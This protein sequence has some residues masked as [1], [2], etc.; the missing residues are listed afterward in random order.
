[1]SYRTAEDVIA[2]AESKGLRYA[3]FVTALQLEM[4]AVLSHI[5]RIGSVVG[6]DGSI[7]ECGIFQDQGNGWIIVVA[8]TGAGNHPAQSVVTYGHRA[9]P[10]FE[11]QILVGVAGSRKTEAPIGSVVASQHVYMPYGG[12][13]GKQGFSSRPRMFPV[14][15]RL[16]AIARKVA[17]EKTWPNRIREPLDHK[18]P[19]REEY[20][21]TF[22]PA[23]TVQPICSTEAV[24]DFTKSELE[25]LI[26]EFYGDTYAVEM[27]GYGAIF[28]ASAEQTPSI[29]VRGVSD[30]THGKTAEADAE[31]QPIAAAHAAA[32]GFEV[33]SHWGQIYSKPQSKLPPMSAPVAPAGESSATRVPSPSA[34]AV[35]GE[36]SDLPI[37]N[38]VLNLSGAIEDVTPEWQDRMTSLLQ[39]LGGTGG[40]TIV[41]AEPGSIRLFVSD[42]N[43]GLA[44]VGLKEL[45]S[46]TAQ[47]LNIDVIGL[48]SLDQF[49]RSGTMIQRLRL[50]STDLLNWP[51]AL[52]GGT[53]IARPELSTLLE[54]IENSTSSATV[55]L[56]D[57]GAGKSALLSTL[58]NQ[59]VEANWPVL[60]IK[61]DSLDPDVATEAQLQEFLDLPAPPSELIEQIAQFQPV[62]VV[63]DQLDALAGYLDIRTARLSA[64]LNLVRR[65]GSLDNVH[66][67]LSSRTFEFNHDTR[68]RAIG[69][70]QV[71]LELPA[72]S[73]VIDILER[74]GINAS[75]WPVD[76]QEVMRRPQAL[77]TYLKLGAREQ[78]EPFTTY[79][80]VLAELWRERVLSGASGPRRADL[81]AMIADQM[82]EEESLWL[83]SV[84][85]E[86]RQEDL[87]ALAAAGILSPP[88]ESISFTHQTLFEFALARS[89]AREQGRLSNYV[90][91]RQS[92]LFLRPKLW[93]GL[94]YLRD[95]DVNAYQK[96][97]REIWAAKDLRVHLRLLL[98]DFLGQQ[99]EPTDGEAL[100]MEGA[101]Q[102]NDERWRAFRAIAGSKGWFDRFSKTFIRQAMAAGGEA[103]DRMI[104]LLAR[105]WPFAS[106]AV[107][108]LIDQVWLENSVNDNRTWAVLQSAS[109]WTQRSVEQAKTIIRRTDV[110]PSRIDWIVASIGVDQPEFA[111]DLVRASLDRTLA[112]AISEAEE[113]A[114]VPPPTSEGDYF[115]WHVR[116]SPD[117][118]FKKAIEDS[119]DWDSLGALAEQNARLVLDSLWPWFLQALSEL[120]RFTDRVDHPASYPIRYHIDL[121]LPDETERG[122]PEGAVTGAIRIA[123]EQIAGNDPSDFLAWV[124]TQSGV[125][126]APV[127]KLIAYIFG[128]H[129]EVYASAA[130]DF[131]LGDQ[132]RLSLGGLSH[133]RSATLQLVEAVSPFWTDDEVRRYEQAIARFTFPLLADETTPE[134][135]RD[136]LRFERR[137]KL[138][139]LRALPAHRRSAA[140]RNRVREEERVFGQADHALASGGGG[141]IG[142]P[143]SAEAMRKA[144]DESIVRAFEVLPDATGWDHPRQFLM[145][146]NIQLS[147]E[148]ATFAAQDPARAERIIH[149]LVPANGT[150][151]AG[152]A[153]DAMGDAAP[154]AVVW[155]VL[156]DVVRRGFDGEEFRGSAARAVQKLVDRKEATPDEVV[157]ILEQWITTPCSDTADDAEQGEE[158]LDTAVSD[159][160]KRDDRLQHSLVWGNGGAS[161]LPQGDF[162][163]LE[164]LI[165]VRLERQESDLLIRSLDAF[166]DKQQDSRTWEHLLRLVSYI[167]PTDPAAFSAFLRN[168]FSSVP[169]LVGTRG[170]AHFLAHLHWREP[171]VLNQQLEAW[172]VSPQ[173][174]ARMAYGE[175]VGI[176]ALTNEKLAWGQE[177]T[178]A[179]LHDLNQTEA[180]V[181]LAITCSHLWPNPTYH[182]RANTMLLRL[183]EEG[184][185]EIWEA[186][187]DLF[188]L[189]DQL[190][191]DASTKNLLTTMADRIT[192]APR[193]NPIFVVEQLAR[194]LPHHPQLVGRLAHGLVAHWK[195]D[196]SDVRTSA[197]FASSD[198]VDLA[199]TLHRLG[200][201]TREVGTSLFEQLLAIE[202]YTA[203]ETLAEL[204]GRFKDAPIAP[205][206]RLARRSRE[207]PSK[208]RSRERTTAA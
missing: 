201:D 35:G 200:P 57:P 71:A 139:L 5:E 128:V 63:I 54:R 193:L 101:L 68:L 199:V 170:T 15:N 55:V 202:A 184:P 90:L 108:D 62:L 167:R 78:S 129:P 175:I 125:E 82:A 25:A 138:E 22:P 133:I 11:T 17:L 114:K 191:P 118:P 122:L 195:D 2:E 152:Y 10:H 58:A 166:L 27:E 165:R 79:Q 53:R 192:E 6:H 87:I 14:D 24:L 61:A 142:S 168:L 186:V 99:R 44:R 38:V 164:A 96:E 100:L 187:F 176:V 33:L 64:L 208:R 48:T 145:G 126:L 148:F 171:D 1:M 117:A 130:L 97:L 123:L 19:P 20:P 12:K 37:A 72:L 41:R 88:D 188:R 74:E 206:R 177:R 155:S 3:F 143:V 135:R 81:L 147:R 141:L 111:I 60:G 107:N 76:A 26:A 18:L 67:V 80:S 59:F 132:R 83:A 102:Q 150:R 98:I 52:P 179:L 70:E 28:A 85:F 157:A 75:G 156:I 34:T 49:E 9:F 163:V 174:N 36:P 161:I 134:E 194:L 158:L 169:T 146:G 93:A 182:E 162:P 149:R 47:A 119:Q 43:R 94:T 73:T 207:R 42:P 154:A 77:A 172:R 173:P 136:R 86:D 65:V 39:E 160:A 40:I 203:L 121:R 183:L 116:H 23:S 7:Y 103:A 50:A 185:V 178:D 197:A 115:A 189:V 84:R 205:R 89:F 140:A 110:A 105:A 190:P 181:G 131:L 137:A 13:W 21:V 32:F 51:Q 66:V 106:A 45:R 204:D 92:S 196:L 4:E 56:G 180:R 112:Q 127:Q 151:A 16:V 153:L 29:V 69:A 104:E 120:R 30:M 95:V 109:T 124:K 198:L 159:D 31:R 113:R 8:Q 46:A 91:A 144:G